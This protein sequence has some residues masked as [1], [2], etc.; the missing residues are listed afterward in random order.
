MST[1][2]PN[3]VC[4][5]DG[6]WCARQ[7][8]GRTSNDSVVVKIGLPEVVDRSES[9]VPRVLRPCQ[10]F[11]L[12]FCLSIMRCYDAAAVHWSHPRSETT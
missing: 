7:I 4:Q 1:A 10:Q 11:V 3:V 8:V 2:L 6:T 9:T 5:I 12:T